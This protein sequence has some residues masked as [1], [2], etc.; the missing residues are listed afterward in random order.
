MDNSTANRSNAK[1]YISICLLGNVQCVGSTEAVD[2]L[3]LSFCAQAIAMIWNI[4]Q[5][6]RY[7]NYVS[8]MADEGFSFMSMTG[9]NSFPASIRIYI[10]LLQN[11][12]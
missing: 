12:Y 3:S 7:E 2:F 4:L 10:A 8:L 6:D 5:F 1:I 9:G 11:E